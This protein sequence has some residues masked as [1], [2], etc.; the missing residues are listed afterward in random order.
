M[1]KENTSTAC[2]STSGHCCK[3]GQVALLV[4]VLVGAVFAVMSY[5]KV[6]SLESK[7]ADMHRMSVT[8]TF[9][10]SKNLNDLLDA[11][12]TSERVKEINANVQDEILRLKGASATTETTEAADTA[13]DTATSGTPVSTN[14][15]LNDPKWDENS[16]EA[17]KLFGLQGTP[18]NALINVKNGNFK[19]IGGAYPQSDFEQVVAAL[20]AGEKLTTDQMGQAGTLTPEQIAAVLK[21]VHYYGSADADIVIVEYS[22]ILCPFCQ[23][24]FSQRTIENIVDANPKVALVFKNMPIAGLH[25]T[26]PIGAKGVECAGQLGGTEAFYNYLTKAFEYSTFN[27]SNVVKI[28]EEIGLDKD[29]FVA[30]F[31]K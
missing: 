20:A 24:Q 16:N 28:A 25:P 26:A 10:S 14:A 6:M 1:K 9:G 19:A 3:F 27:G 13:G 17:G 4:L 18:G 2:C 8:A 30:C 23:R 15:A 11:T 21:D 7:L 5:C 31:T 12:L 29:S 22:D